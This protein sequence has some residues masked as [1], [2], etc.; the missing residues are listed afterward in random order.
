MEEKTLQPEQTVSELANEVLTRQAKARAD[1][2]GEPIEEAMEAVLNT[3]AGRELRELRDGPHGEEGVQEA[4]VEAAR[5]RVRQRAA[6]LGK[7]LGE[8]PG[9]PTHG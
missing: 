3:E 9:S 6:D 2:G 8:A 1:R 4:Q 5:D 7:R